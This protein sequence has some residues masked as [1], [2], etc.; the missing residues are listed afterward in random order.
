[1]DSGKISVDRAY[2][3][4][5]NQERKL[6]PTPNLPKGKFEIIVAD[7]P[8]Q[9]DFDGRGAPEYKTMSIEEIKNEIPKLP[10]HDN[11]KLFLWA[12]NPKIELGIELM[13][14]WGFTY[15]TNWTWVKMKNGKLQKGPGYHAWS[16]SE[17]ILIGTKGNMTPLEGTLESTVIFA[18][19]TKHSV[20]PEEFFGIVENQNPE[21]EKL[22][23]FARK[24]RKG[25]TVWGD[26]VS[27]LRKNVKNTYRGGKN[28]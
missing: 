23:M 26:E 24:D 4:I 3:R 19:R 28:E 20:K 6:T 27:C 5:K 2:R 15:T 13:N 11:C 14:F 17:Q 22:E 21:R 7:I 10:A 25:W 18:E 12:T 9:Y 8:W 1:M 16:S